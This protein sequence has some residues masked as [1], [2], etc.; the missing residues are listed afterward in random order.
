MSRQYHYLVAGLPD[1]YIDDNKI[2]F[3]ST[4]F[5]SVLEE[6]LPAED[7]N[8]IRLF[9]WR[10]DNGNVL[11]KLS[12]TESEVDNKGNLDEQEIEDIIAAV[13]D[14]SFSEGLFG[15]PGYFGK[16]ID[17]YKNETP[18]IKGKS[19]DL[20]FS[21]LYF[22]YV[23]TQN[24]TFIR[25]WFQFESDLN[26]L[27]TASKCKKYDLPIEGQLIGSGDLVDRLSRSS[28]KD[29]GLDNEFPFLDQ[30][31]KALD[32]N[33]LLEQEKKIDRVK[34]EYLNEEVFFHYFTIEKIFAFMV[35]LSLVERWLSLDKE[36]GQQLFNELIN[37]METSYEFP[38][39]FQ[40][41]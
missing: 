38:E 23:I 8:I 26:N 21:E 31:L 17:G 39:E 24:N 12:D 34:W 5:R 10:F 16:M 2:S 1:I 25:K 37:N 15:V 22:D 29:F 13:K 19:W 18:V 28:S 35:Q 36:T 40:L 32:E 30:I 4:E 33:D 9:F 11:S 7:M 6:S 20:Q 3:G 14:D 41:K 27:L